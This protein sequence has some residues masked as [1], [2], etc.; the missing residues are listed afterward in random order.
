MPILE[1]EIDVTV[2]N[3]DMWDNFKVL[4]YIDNACYFSFYRYLT[5]AFCNALFDAFDEINETGILNV[6]HQQA[7]DVYNNGDKTHDTYSTA[8]FNV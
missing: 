3:T 1:K 6:T 5:E 4:D 7:Y 8:S 2:K